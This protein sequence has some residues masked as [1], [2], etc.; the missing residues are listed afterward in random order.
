[1]VRGREGDVHEVDFGVVEHVLDAA[2]GA[3]VGEVL[4]DDVPALAHEVADRHDPEE[5][6][7]RA[8]GGDVVEQRRAPEARDADADGRTLRRGNRWD[9]LVHC[10][11]LHAWFHTFPLILAKHSVPVNQRVWY[12]RRP[13]EHRTCAS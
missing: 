9:V 1:M 12:N 6:R 3:D 8:E 11:Q 4:L 7:R 13:K 2:V 5:V 10:A